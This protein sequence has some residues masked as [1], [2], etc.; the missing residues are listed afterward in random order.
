MMWNFEEW[1]QH[2]MGFGFHWIFMLV[3]WGLVIWAAFSLVR[4]AAAPKGSGAAPGNNGKNGNEEAL[5]VLKTRYARGE[6]SRAQFKS[7]REDVHEDVS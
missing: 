6:L 4:L 3:F 5:A 2:G 7:M 1:W